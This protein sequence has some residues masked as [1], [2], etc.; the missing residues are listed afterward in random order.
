MSFLGLN[1][2]A[3][4][5]TISACASRAN[6]HT[7]ENGMS[8]FETLYNGPRIVL[9]PAAAKERASYI[10]IIMII[11]NAHCEFPAAARV[12]NFLVLFDPLFFYKQ[13]ATKVD[14]AHFAHL[15]HKLV[16]FNI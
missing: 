10:I 6:S 5:C 4:V 1:V 12:V 13:G 15:Q 3:V 11:H 7:L 14:E 8:S 9:S 2:N 16:C